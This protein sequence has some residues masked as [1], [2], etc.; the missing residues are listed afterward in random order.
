MLF[1]S[2]MLRH[3]ALWV[4]DGV[5]SVDLR[6]LETRGDVRM[7][8]GVFARQGRGVTIESSEGYLAVAPDGTAVHGTSARGALAAL[9]RR[10]NE[11]AQAARIQH[12]VLSQG[13]MA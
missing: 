1:R 2:R 7:F 8:A 12:R 13:V 10:R 3:A 4:V 11:A 6:L 5:V 9:S